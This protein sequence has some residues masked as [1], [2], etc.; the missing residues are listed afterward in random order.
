[1]TKVGE[2]EEKLKQYQGRYQRL[3]KTTG[4]RSRSGTGV[5]GDE[6]IDVQLDVLTKMIS[7]LREEISQL[8][9][10]RK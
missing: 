2:L 7:D 4:G 1:M 10:M 6:V 8:K 3:L 9:R 5:A